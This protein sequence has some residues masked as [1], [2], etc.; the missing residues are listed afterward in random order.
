MFF[1]ALLCLISLTADV[2]LAQRPTLVVTTG[3]GAGRSPEI[4]VQPQPRI[5]GPNSGAS[6]DQ[7]LASGYAWEGFNSTNYVST[8]PF[9]TQPP[10]PD[11]A[12]GPTDILILTNRNIGRVPNINNPVLDSWDAPFN[13]NAGASGFIYAPWTPITHRALL[14]A[15]IGPTAL[16]QM[17][18]ANAGN[19]QVCVVGNGT[20][21]FDQRQGRFVVLM[22]VTH[23]G[24]PRKAYWVLLV[25]RF[26]TV[27]YNPYDPSNPSDPFI[28]PSTAAANP[29][30]GQINTD[31]W[32]MWY[33]NDANANVHLAPYDADG[34]GGP[35]GNIN[36]ISAVGAT[37]T[38]GAPY[39]GVFD[40]RASARRNVVN[41]DMLPDSDPLGQYIATP[42]TYCY[43]PTD[44]K[45]GFD[46][47][48]IILTSTVVNDNVMNPGVNPPNTQL[49]RTN[50]RYPGYAGTRVRV[51]KK[52]AFYIGKGVVP[53]STNYG[54]APQPTPAVVS[55]VPGCPFPQA[56][57]GTL[58]STATCAG[59][60]HAYVFQGDF[61]DLYT[62]NDP[63]PRTDIITGH[64]VADTPNAVVTAQ[65]ALPSA[66]IYQAPYT[67]Y[68]ARFGLDAEDGLP[69]IRAAGLLDS[70][71]WTPAMGRGRTHAY[72]S[73]RIISG[74]AGSAF[75]LPYNPAFPGSATATVAFNYLVGSRSVPYSP[76]PRLNPAP[77][78][79]LNNKL[80]IQPIAYV[81]SGG[82][83]SYGVVL[84]DEGQYAN[85]QRVL[86][87][88]YSDPANVPQ[89]GTTTLI[90]TG[91]A[92]VHKAVYREGYLSVAR[93]ANAPQESLIQPS[94]VTLSNALATT[95]FYEVIQTFQAAPTTQS[96]PNPQLIMSTHW[97]NGHFYSPMFDVPPNVVQRAAYNPIDLYPYLE[98]LFV[99]TTSNVG[100]YGVQMTGT[101]PTDPFTFPSYTRCSASNTFAGPPSV[102]AASLIF[103]SLFDMRCGEAYYQSAVPYTDPATGQK[104]GNTTLATG[105][106]MAA[107]NANILGDRAGGA[108]DPV[109]GSLWAYGAYARRQFGNQVGA[110]QW[111]TFA[112]NYKMTFQASDLYGNAYGFFPDVPL[113]G[114]GV[115]PAGWFEAVEVLRRN[116]LWD[117]G[118]NGA[119]S[120][121]PVYPTSNFGVNTTVLRKEMARLVILSMMDISD[122][123]ALTAGIPVSA[124]ADVAVTDP[125]WKYIELM[126]RLGI[127]KGCAGSP[128][129][130]DV[131]LQFCPNDS[132]TRAQMAVFLI[133]AKMNN[134]FP[135]VNN[136][137]PVTATGILNCPG[138]ANLAT[139]GDNFGYFTVAQPYFADVTTTV[140]EQAPWFI[141]V[142]KMMELRITTGTG[143]ATFG[144]SNVL[145]RGQLA[146]FL[147]RAF[148]Y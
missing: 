130:P 62:T 73:N 146:V 126:Y 60:P 90:N 59:N 125:Y 8:E 123:N 38:G 134:V 89:N 100:L 6:P 87:N 147:A 2:A 101:F 19:T 44:A 104:F 113:G 118:A 85:Y 71:L 95:V 7:L 121:S 21:R 74:L 55:L 105:T 136:G 52:S 112:A 58:P 69:I 91:K 133:R 96:Y 33:G 27:L 122:V 79:L 102:T 94:P 25:S 49:D 145:T 140:P 75:N 98:K 18:G 56:A 46:D 77:W 107:P 127:T 47:D 16:T 86:V 99:G 15:W 116:G 148:F 68:A 92:V 40:C 31:A 66:R 81:T 120:V 24:N 9:I 63:D 3:S 20:V 135:T 42:S 72:Y 22:T 106:A 10:N 108:I 93:T 67:L 5:P 132:L 110:G 35:Y 23:L 32:M 64:E 97:R 142:Q 50:F 88:A 61:Y 128:G 103:P 129:L 111:G 48:N 144:F 141:Y 36:A 139:T 57:V 83:F 114:G 117:F 82:A 53:A 138:S 12:T 45:L 43:F 34:F 80:F 51:L 29:P 30:F 124:F 70:I 11:I 119:A 54:V 109:D 84:P 4:A 26:A 1:A 17:C 37:V 13:R 115:I 28:T 137:C 41:W 131:L 143:P 65:Y 76:D 14:D 78:P 39:A